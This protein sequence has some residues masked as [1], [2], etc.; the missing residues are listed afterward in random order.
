MLIYNTFHYMFIYIYPVYMYISLKLTIGA[1][2][3]KYNNNI[4]FFCQINL[5]HL[6]SSDNITF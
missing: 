1:L 5:D 6:C 2:L 3:K 4:F